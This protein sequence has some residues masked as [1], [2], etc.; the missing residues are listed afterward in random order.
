MSKGRLLGK[1]YTAEV[2]EWED[3]K[4]LKLYND[5]CPRSL[6]VR[7]FETTSN[8]YYRLG[9]CPKSFEVV[10]LDGRCGVVY[11]RVRGTMFMQ[12]MLLPIWSLRRK[13]RLFAR[14][15]RDIH[16]EVPF[17]LPDVKEYMASAIGK[18]RELTAE[19]K[20]YL[21]EYIEQLPGGNIMCHMDFHPQNILMGD[22]K[23]VVIDW[24]T[25]MKG[26]PM[27]DVARTYV[28]LNY[29]VPPIKARLLQKLF[30]AIKTVM[31]KEYLQEYLRIADIS[32]EAVERWT[33]PIAAA[34][35]NEW[36]PAQEKQ[37]LL[38]FV[39]DE[40]QKKKMQKAK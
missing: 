2:Y 7:E 35:L 36:L 1:G 24:M 19:E 9:I 16:Q 13:T 28:I 6:C 40:L 12:W 38:A 20:V 34:R 31:C 4:I 37:T 8:V 25:A 22:N 26:C 30:S 11:Q 17:E 5:G 15:H 18:L 3:D 27:A 21:Y 23:P 39:R 32:M 29:H 14:L 33:L 10:E